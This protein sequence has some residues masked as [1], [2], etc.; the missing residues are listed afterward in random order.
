V[1]QTGLKSPNS[2]DGGGS[3]CKRE[4]RSWMHGSAECEQETLADRPLMTDIYDPW[5]KEGQFKR[6]VEAMSRTFPLFGIAIESSRSS[7]F[8][9]L[10]PC[11][12]L[13]SKTRVNSAIHAIFCTYQADRFM[14]RAHMTCTLI[15]IIYPPVA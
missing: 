14:A 13:P 2:R 12:G 9:F 4:E 8:R 11:K 10:I 6:S 5:K 7:F 1:R 3:D 15:D